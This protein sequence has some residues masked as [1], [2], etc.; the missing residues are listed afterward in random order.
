M[1]LVSSIHER[2]LRE[3]DNALAVRSGQSDT[4]RVIDPAA[5]IMISVFL[6][7]VLTGQR[8]LA[9]FGI[10]FTAAVLLDAFILRAVLGPAI[11]LSP[12]NWWLPPWLDRLLPHIAIEPSRI[13]AQKPTTTIL[14]KDP[15]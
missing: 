2:S 4:G 11:M 5:A 15:P 9:E 1:F 6:A 12:A 13:D 3:G 14:Q 10:G 7:F 8:L